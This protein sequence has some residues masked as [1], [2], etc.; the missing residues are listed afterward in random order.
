MFVPPWKKLRLVIHQHFCTVYVRLIE[1]ATHVIVGSPTVRFQISRSIYTDVVYG[2]R[3][4]DRS[5]ARDVNHLRTHCPLS[6]QLSYPV[7]VMDH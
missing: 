7:A 2:T 1:Q 4:D 6:K 3:R 5:R